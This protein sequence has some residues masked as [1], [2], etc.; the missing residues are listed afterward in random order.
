[1]SYHSIYTHCEHTGQRISRTF[2]VYSK[3]QN[4]NVDRLEKPWA[5]AF[6]P[7]EKQRLD[8]LGAPVAKNLPAKAGKTG[9]IPGLGILHMRQEN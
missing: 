6:T 5:C 9:L 4:E 1:M 3:L 7:R 2:G 8:F